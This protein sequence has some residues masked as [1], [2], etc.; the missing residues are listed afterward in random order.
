MKIGPGYAEEEL[1]LLE[2]FG[3]DLKDHFVLNPFSGRDTFH[4]P[5]FLH[6]PSNVAWNISKDGQPQ[7]V[8]SSQ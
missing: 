7:L 5:R 4:C 2:W 6:A 3:K 8:L 1:P